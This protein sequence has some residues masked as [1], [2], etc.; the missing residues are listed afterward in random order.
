MSKNV[1]ST[2]FESLKRPLS[3]INAELLRQGR[4]GAN[5]LASALF[6]GNAF[7][8]YGSGQKTEAPEVQQE[9]QPRNENSIER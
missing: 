5:E 9:V 8:I 2:L 6:N 1:A 4:Q 7:V 3:E